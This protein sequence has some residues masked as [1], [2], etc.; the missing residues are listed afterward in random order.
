M[1]PELSRRDVL[2]LSGLSVL[3]LAGC[4]PQLSTPP[5][6]TSTPYPTATHIPFPTDTET[7]SPTDTP[8]PSSTPE[9]LTADP[10]VKESWPSWAQE[11]FANPDNA[12]DAQDA[13]FDQFLTDARKSYFERLGQNDPERFRTLLDFLVQGSVLTSATRESV[14]GMSQS[15]MLN[16][17]QSMYENDFG[18]D[19]LPRRHMLWMNVINNAIEKRSTI[20]SPNEIRQITIDRDAYFKPWYGLLP[21]APEELAQ[22]TVTYGFGSFKYPGIII[23]QSPM[24]D[25]LQLEIYGKEIQ[26]P[27][28]II[29]YQALNGDLA[30]LVELPRQDGFAMLMRVRNEQGQPFLHIFHLEDE[31]IET[32][33]VSKLCYGNPSS[34]GNVVLMQCPVILNGEMS[35][36]R[37]YPDGFHR[38]QRG[39]VL[40]DD[41]V[42]EW[43]QWPP[44]YAQH[45]VLEN[46]SGWIVHYM[47]HP[48]SNLLVARRVQIF[49]PDERQNQP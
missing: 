12:T 38:G 26:N 29:F 23:E 3:F 41:A 22:Y 4:R 49:P 27:L 42:R 36:F 28:K 5:I 47:Y 2:K 18:Q 1:T 44:V 32:N 31:G 8:E 48:R 43:L 40:D 14:A 6:D 13:Q 20:L 19:F 17:L 33:T 21:S 10:N 30:G 16:T 15:D 25:D 45:D 11:Y 34:G 37:V 39:Q 9:W 46:P 35:W 7:P 24:F